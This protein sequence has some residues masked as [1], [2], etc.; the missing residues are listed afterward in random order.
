[1][2]DGKE[3]PVLYFSLDAHQFHS[4]VRVNLSPNIKTNACYYIVH[5]KN[6]YRPSPDVEMSTSVT[7]LSRQYSVFKNTVSMQPAFMKNVDAKVAQKCIEY[8]A[9]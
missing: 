3:I 2:P 5:C 4:T 1:V 7:W 6:D 8:I 9:H